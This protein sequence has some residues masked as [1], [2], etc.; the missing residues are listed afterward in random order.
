M[1][2]IAL[3]AASTEKMM[4]ESEMKEIANSGHL[5]CRRLVTNMKLLAECDITEAEQSVLK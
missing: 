4:L 5:R 1:Q 3:S 2:V